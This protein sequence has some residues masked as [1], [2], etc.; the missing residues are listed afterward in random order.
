MSKIL[1]I[2]QA[3]ELFSNRRI[4]TTVHFNICK[5]QMVLFSDDHC[6]KKIIGTDDWVP[7][8]QCFPIGKTHVAPRDRLKDGIVRN[9]HDFIK[10]FLIEDQI[11]HS[12]KE[13]ID[14]IIKNKPHMAEA[15]QKQ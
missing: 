8:T 15:F 9:I 2:Q 13:L 4:V 14:L 11:V 12:E 7:V 1:T 6:I 5:K 3:Q 10:V